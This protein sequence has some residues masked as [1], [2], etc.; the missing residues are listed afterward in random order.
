MTIIYSQGDLFWIETH[1]LTLAIGDPVG[2]DISGAVAPDKVG[3]FLGGCVTAIFADNN[4]N[5]Q[6]VGTTELRIN[7]LTPVINGR[8]DSFQVRI[9][10]QVGTGGA[11]NINYLIMLYMRKAR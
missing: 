2:R 7:G 5:C 11:A 6:A 3:L 1:E 4:D 10:K 8:V 9:N